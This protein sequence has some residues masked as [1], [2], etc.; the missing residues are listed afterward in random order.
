MTQFADFTQV[1][2]FVADFEYVVKHP[3]KE[4]S[5]VYYT[6]VDL[7]TACTVVATLD[8]NKRPVAGRYLYPEKPVVRDGMVVDYIG[9]VNIVRHMK[10]EIEEELGTELRWGAA[11]IPPGTDTLDGGAV[12]NVTESAGFTV[13]SAG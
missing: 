3:I 9:A 1:D 5:S 4:R 13:K 2:K 12:R 7:G 6:G 11:A 8:E 10:E